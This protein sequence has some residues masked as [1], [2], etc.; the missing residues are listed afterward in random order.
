MPEATGTAGA[1]RIGF[2]GTGLIGTPMVQ[3]L[4]ECG[5]SVTVWNRTID[6]AA[7]LVLDVT[8]LAE[9]PRAREA[10]DAF[11]EASGIEP[12]VAYAP[13]EVGGLVAMNT[14]AKRI[15]WDHETIAKPETV[16]RVVNGVV[17][18]PQAGM[19][20]PLGLPSLAAEGIPDDATATLAIAATGAK[21]AVLTD[22]FD[23]N[24]DGFLIPRA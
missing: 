12:V 8:T 2:I 10:I 15:E 14:P 6:K 23:V 19:R 20:P 9:S 17:V 13:P 11:R 22:A 24:K 5:L 18:W 16:G 1:P 3:R 21:V 4:L 7:P